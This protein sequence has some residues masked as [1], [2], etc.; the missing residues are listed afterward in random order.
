M[1][2][3]SG[4]GEIRCWNGNRIDSDS[5]AGL[6]IRDREDPFTGNGEGIDQQDTDEQV[7]WPATKTGTIL[8]MVA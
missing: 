6:I 3:Y 8:A 7:P 4:C 1:T 5:V 2:D